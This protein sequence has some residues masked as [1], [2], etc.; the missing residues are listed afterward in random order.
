MSEHGA[1]SR[2]RLLAAVGAAAGVTTGLV[3]AEPARAAAAFST[4]ATAATGAPWHRTVTQ[5]GWPVVD[6]DAV[7]RVK[8]EGS[9]AAVSVLPGDVATVLEH[10]ARRY[11]Y[12]VETLGRG[13]VRGHVTDRDVDAPQ[14]SNYLSGTALAIRPESYPAGAQGNM[15]ARQLLVIRDILADCGGVVRWGG[16]NQD[17]PKEGHFQIDVAPGDLRLAQLA[18]RIRDRQTQPGGDAGAPADVLLTARRTA[19]QSLQ[20]RQSGR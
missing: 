14:E 8:I 11:H 5:N 12:E 2:R 7:T 10:V 18:T 1:W 17:A 20:R 16:D 13:D 9:D 15:F 6:G 19:A 4:P 3:T